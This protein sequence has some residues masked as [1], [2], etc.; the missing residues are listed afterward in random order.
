MK[1]L[2]SLVLLLPVLLAAQTPI[3]NIQDSTS[4]YDGRQV[5]IEGVVT[6][7]ANTTNNLRL[8]AFIQDSSGKGMMLF[9]YDLTSAYEADII[10]GNRLNVTGTVDEYNGVTELT[11]FTYTVLET[12]VSISPYIVPLSLTQADDSAE[13]EGTLCQVNGT[14]YEDP[15]VSGG[16]TNLNLEDTG[17]HQLTVRVWASTGI[18]IPSLSEGD[19]LTANGVVGIYNGNAQV[20]PGYQEDLIVE[21]TEKPVISNIAY[22][23]AAPAATDPITVTATITTPTAPSRKPCWSGN[24]LVLPTS[25]TFS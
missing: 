16:G 9:S 2:L 10:R 5:S 22:T 3:A 11:D 25:R 23:P 13:W 20:L 8:N 12:G 21:V 15:Y 18:T 6:I 24:W 7:G 1:Q 4:V 17:G 14:L 19:E